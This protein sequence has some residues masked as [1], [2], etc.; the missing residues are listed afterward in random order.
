MK[1]CGKT[2]TYLEDNSCKITMECGTSHKGITYL[3]P[4][5]SSLTSNK[6][7]KTESQKFIDAINKSK[8]KGHQF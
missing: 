8:L 2:F 3:C 7:P 5:C 4:K 6:K 1:G